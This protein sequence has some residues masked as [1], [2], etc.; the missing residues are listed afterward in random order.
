[1]QFMKLKIIN[2]HYLDEFYVN[3]LKHTKLRKKVG[4]FPLN[5]IQVPPPIPP[6]VTKK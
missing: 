1:M 4:I 3:N 6:K 5:D 2:Y